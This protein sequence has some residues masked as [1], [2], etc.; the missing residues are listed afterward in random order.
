MLLLKEEEYMNIDEKMLEKA[1]EKK[2]MLQKIFN[3]AS[4]GEAEQNIPLEEDD[5]EDE[6]E[7]EEELT[8]G[9]ETATDQTE[10]NNNEENQDKTE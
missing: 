3:H 7:E 5:V 6:H 1:D 10:E 9:D 2:G 4:R 8:E